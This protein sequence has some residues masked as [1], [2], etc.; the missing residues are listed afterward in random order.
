MKFKHLI[1]YI[2]Y[3]MNTI[4]TKDGYLIN[5]KSYDNKF[6]NSIRNDLTVQPFK[7]NYGFS[8]NTDDNIDSF[9]VYRETEDYL[10]IPKFYGYEK[11]GLPTKN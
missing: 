5:K 2:L 10:I 4:L 8:K 6:L 7:L 3:I 11:M 1:L 9:S